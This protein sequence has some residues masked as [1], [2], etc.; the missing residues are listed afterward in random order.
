MTQVNKH[1]T[2]IIIP[3]HNQ[4]QYTKLCVESMYSF[5]DP[6]RFELIVIDN[7]STDGSGD[8]LTGLGHLNLSVVRFD[9]NKGVA[10]AWNEGLRRSK[11]NVIGVLNNDIILTP[12]WL[13]NIL[14]AFDDPMVWCACPL[15]SRF[16]LPEDFDE[17]A[18]QIHENKPVYQ[19]I[20]HLTGFCFFVR[21]QAFNELG[22]FDEQFA[23]GWFEDSDFNMRLHRS[24]HPPVQVENVL[25]HHFESRT[26]INTPDFF[27]IYPD[28][29]AEKFGKKWNI[30][31]MPRG[32]DLVPED[33][34]DSIKA[35]QYP[36]N[37]EVKK[38]KK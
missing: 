22:G 21:A 5:A 17:L 9:E 37:Y 6:D 20:Q 30:D 34:V 8:W 13:E 38:F 24:G 31:N 2:S 27:D 18:R 33:L 16:D 15:Y 35:V 26:L 23:M 32:K 29:N 12:D 3:I 4:L 28:Q 19:R 11:G 36:A 1:F 14:K 10:P 25:I 7:A